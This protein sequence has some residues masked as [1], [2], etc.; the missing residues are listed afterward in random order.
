MC[1]RTLAA[2]GA[3]VLRIASPSLPFIHW[4]VID[5]GRGKRSAFVDLL[6]ADGRA[7]LV[8]LIE[9]ADVFVQGYR[10]G[11]LAAL[12]FAPEDV[13][14]IRPGIVYVSLSAYSHVGPWAERRGFDSLVQTATGF[15]HEEGRAA[16][17]DGPKELPAQALD[18]GSGQLMAFAAM[19]A[20]ARQAR[21]GG[22]YRVRVS[23]AQTGRWIWNL[24]RVEN[25]LEAND[26]KQ[27]DVSDRIEES[28]SAFGRL[29]AVRHSAELSETP[30]YFSRPAAP[31]GSNEPVWEDRR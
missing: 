28:D 14:R 15:N 29:R 24:G 19:A 10:P 17:S 30:A 26:P 20:R 8:R 2:H 13:A 12:G 31:L 1:G 9:Q 16:G 5:T 25:G 22:S 23:L 18:H 4:L 7:T 11:A 27:D 3:D 21:E 6:T